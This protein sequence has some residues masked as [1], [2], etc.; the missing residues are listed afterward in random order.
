MDT[1]AHESTSQHRPRARWWVVATILILGGVAYW[2]LQVREHLDE[3]CANCRS[4]LVGPLR[5]YSG[6]NDGWYPRGGVN[7]L[8]SLAKCAT[9]GE[10]HCFTSHALAPK[11]HEHWKKNHTFAPEFICYR[12]NEGLRDGDPDGLIVL[13]F[14]KPTFWECKSSGHKKSFLGRPVMLTPVSLSWEFLPED[15]F[16]KRQTNTVAYLEAKGRLKQTAKAP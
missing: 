10:V 15:E 14:H 4:Q 5:E 2:F 7:P 1:K 11:L 13:Y 12:Y 16:Q 8:D 9:D 6:T 3:S